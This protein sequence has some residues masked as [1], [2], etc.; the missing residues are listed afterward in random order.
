MGNHDSCNAFAHVLQAGGYR[1][2]GHDFAG[3]G[4]REAGFHFES[5]HLAA[6]AN[7]DVSQG[8]RAEVHDPFHLDG[9]GIN[10]ESL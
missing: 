8:L 6:L 7:G 1:K 4:D 9:I 2:N 10:V 5:I 3:N